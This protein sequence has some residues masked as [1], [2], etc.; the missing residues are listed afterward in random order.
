MAASPPTPC[1]APLASAIT[2]EAQM[3][4]VQDLAEHWLG[5]LHALDIPAAVEL[6]ADDAVL[7]MPFAPRASRIG[8]RGRR[9]SAHFS[10]AANT[11]RSWSSTTSR[12]T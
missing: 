6:L 7:E 10:V 8:L 1:S 12:S 4:E 5:A 9:P 2:R 3:S 11:S